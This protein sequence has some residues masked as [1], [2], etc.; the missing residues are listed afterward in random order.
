MQLTIFDKPSSYLFFD[1]LS[2]YISFLTNPLPISFLT[3]PLANEWTCR[4]CKIPF[5]LQKWWRHK[6]LDKQKRLSRN[7]AYSKNESAFPLAVS[8]D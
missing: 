1:K 7:H 3:N 6:L 5:T 8:R 4:K 2:S